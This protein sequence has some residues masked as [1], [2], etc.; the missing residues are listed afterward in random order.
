MLQLYFG[1]RYFSIQCL[2]IFR[3]LSA[4]RMDNLH[5]FLIHFQLFSMCLLI[6]YDAPLHAFSHASIGFLVSLLL[7]HRHS[8]N[9]SSELNN[10]KSVG[11][12]YEVPHVSNFFFLCLRDGVLSFCKFLSS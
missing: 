8:L 12:S 7:I 5:H 3:A 9:W 4:Y 2:A 11:P 6:V 10:S 1:R